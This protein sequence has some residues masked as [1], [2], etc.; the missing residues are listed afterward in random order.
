MIKKQYNQMIRVMVLG[1]SGVGKTS[2]LST[3]TKGHFKEN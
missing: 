3:Y 2:I 1:D